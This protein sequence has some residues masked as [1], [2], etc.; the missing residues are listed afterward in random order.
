LAA[1]A[2][3]PAGT[4]APGAPARAFHWQQVES[5]D[6]K[7]YIANLRAIGCP[8]ETLRDIVVADVN[9]LF[10]ERAK[11]LT[12]AR[13]FEYWRTGNP[14]GGLL[15]SGAPE[16][17]LALERERRALLRELL[18]I[19][20]EARPE[21]LFGAVNFFETMLDFLPPEQR[22]KLMEVEQQFGL[23]QAK[24]L[25]GGVMDADDHKAL[26][27]LQREKQAALRA[28]LTPEEYRGY[29]LRMSETA[30]VM[31]GQLA[32]FDTTEQ[33]FQQIFDR[34]KAFDEEFGALNFGGLEGEEMQRRSAAEEA[35]KADLKELMG[36]ARYAEY[37]RAQ[38]HEWQFL[39]KIAERN[40]LPPEAAAAAYDMKREA[41]AAA[42]LIRGDAALSDEQRSAALQAVNTETM[43]AL[44]ERLGEKAVESWR[45]SPGGYWMRNLAP[46]SPA[47][48]PAE[49]A[50][51]LTAPADVAAPEQP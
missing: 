40:G 16:R 43:R 14:V 45:K 37:E 13:K 32:G 19:E 20:V 8:E 44:A 46:G 15:D 33:E 7:E 12:P 4:N 25:Q 38:D 26:R 39:N 27:A 3:A 11:A 1:A 6:Y 30:M 28:V 23:K 42:A 21:D 5:A 35:M 34:R 18:G 10:A 47:P 51:I 17:R 48:P 31:R 2:P 29:E 41:E 24:L 22:T 49:D 9:K 36:E 50:V